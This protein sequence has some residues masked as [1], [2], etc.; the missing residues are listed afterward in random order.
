MYTLKKKGEK[1]K[2]LLVI[3]MLLSLSIFASNLKDGRY[4]VEDT[5]YTYGWKS[6]TAITVQNGDIISVKHDK[7]NAKNEYASNDLAYNRNMK[8][9]ANTN[10]E[11]FTKAL[12]NDFMQ[13]KLDAVSGATKNYKVNYYE[14]IDAVDTVAGATTNSNIFKKQMKFLLDKANKGETGKHTL[15]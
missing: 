10:P 14:I 15:K 6:F 5:V 8:L 12:E 4:W 3:A 11:E 13:K 9:S 1:M 2:K 7:I